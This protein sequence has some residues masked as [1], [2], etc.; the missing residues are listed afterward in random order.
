MSEPTVRVHLV[1]ARATEDLGAALASALPTLA[2]GGLVVHLHGDL[3]AGKTTFVRGLLR[4]LGV[5]GIVRSPTYTLVEPYQAG[6][7]TGVHVDLYRLRDP[8]DMEDLA[9]REYLSP[10]TLLLIEWPERGGAETPP[11][12]M[13]I[14]MDYAA[15]GRRAV[16]RSRTVIGTEWLN[17]WQNIAQPDKSL[18]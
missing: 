3:G 16:L 10:L 4:R 8:G 13:E 12:D 2:G 9:L 7:Y 11:A 1:D 6:A 18:I 14:E 15:A 5:T 17:L